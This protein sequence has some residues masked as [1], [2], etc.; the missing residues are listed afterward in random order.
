[1]TQQAGGNLIVQTL[2]GGIALL[3]EGAEVQAVPLGQHHFVST[4][5]NVVVKD[6]V[7]KVRLDLMVSQRWGDH[8]DHVNR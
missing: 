4:G 5:A 8:H 6:G 1:L 2:D 7:A 3:A